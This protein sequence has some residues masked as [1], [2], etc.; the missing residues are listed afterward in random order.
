MAAKKKKTHEDEKMFSFLSETLEEGI[1][2]LYKSISEVAQEAVSE[3]TKEDVNTH[4]DNA[5]A[6]VLCMY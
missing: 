4:L 2:D 6:M 5:S 1:T 3:A